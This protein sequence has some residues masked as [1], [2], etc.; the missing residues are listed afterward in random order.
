MNFAVVNLGCKV[1]RVEADNIISLFLASGAVSVDM[2]LADITIINTCAV[3]GEAEKKTRKAVRRALRANTT[4]RILVIGC[5]ATLFPDDYKS[6]DDRVSV[7]LKTQIDVALRSF[8]ETG[9]IEA[10]LEECHIDSSS[11]SFEHKAKKAPNQLLRYGDRFPT[12]VGV[13]IQDGCNNACS[14]CI[15]HVAR[16]KATSRT[17]DEVIEEV[18][19]YSDAGVKEVVLTGINLGSYNDKGKGLV[20][21]VSHILSKT[22]QVRLRLSSIEPKDVSDELIALLNEADGRICRHLHIPLQSGSDKVLK[23]MNRLYD[24]KYFEELVESL[25][26]SIPSLSLSTDVIVGFPGETE[27]DFKDTLSMLQSARFSK[28]HIFPYSKREGTP[29][30]LRCDQLDDV[31]KSQRVTRITKIADILREE[32]YHRRQT[33][34]E[35]VLIEEDG[36]GTSES[37][38]RIDVAKEL[39]VGQLIEMEL[40]Y[41]EYLYNTKIE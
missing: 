37:Y 12:R 38:H 25:Y 4:S 6:M 36:K 5:A 28:V 2:A 23:E 35:F 40:P 13:K 33:T 10:F 3:T 17:F 14:F 34:K 1:N 39:S 22:T 24:R 27:D 26:D 8:R 9:N 31:T 29:A 15:V 30:A 21:L 18:M 20:D 41:R 16:G 11:F 7:V 19:V 32:D